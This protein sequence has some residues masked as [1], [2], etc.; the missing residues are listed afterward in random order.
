M[1][2]RTGNVILLIVSVLVCAYAAEFL[3]GFYLVKSILHYPV[4]PFSRQTHT[5]VDYSAGYSYNNISLR[6]PDFKPETLYDVVL[7]GDSFIFGQGVDYGDSL[8]G[9]MEKKGYAVQ[10]VSEIATNPID[11]HH[12]LK[13]MLSHGLK[14]RNVVI[15]LCMGNDFQNIGDKQIEQ[16]LLYRYRQ[17]F[18]DYGAIEFIKLEKL[19]YQIRVRW[20]KLFDMARRLID[21]SGHER[22]IVHDFEHPR[23]FNE[24]WVRF[25]AGGK[26]EL[27]KVMRGEGAP[28]IQSRKLTEAEYMEKNGLDD[29]S[30]RNTLR[31]IN[32]IAAA[33]HPAKVWLMLIPDPYYVSGQRFPRYESYVNRLVTGVDKRISIIDLHP[34][35]TPD[36]HF[37]HDGH[38]NVKGHKIVADVISQSIPRSP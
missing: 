38:W 6:G 13:I 20:I 26:E 32:A 37:L 14:T 34:L 25:F 17:S 22:V 29:D 12:K 24:D 21:K 36:M 35:L 3:L 10:N 19:R 30:L 5:T 1:K 23:K 2:F 11:Y 16:A 31:I 8:Q 27:M 33:A 18:L 7:I 4:P 28:S 15:G 9:N